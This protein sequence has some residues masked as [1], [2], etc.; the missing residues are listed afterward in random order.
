MLESINCKWVIIG[1]SERRLIM[2]ETESERRMEY[3]YEAG[4]YVYSTVFII[5][6]ESGEKTYWFKNKRLFKL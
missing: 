4:T 1:H 5:N 3:E 6:V 2:K